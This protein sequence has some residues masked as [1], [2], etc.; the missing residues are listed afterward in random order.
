MQCVPER[1]T[2]QLALA[3]ARPDALIGSNFVREPSDATPRYTAWLNGLTPEQLATQFLREVTLARPTWF[4]ARG[5]YDRA[6]PFFPGPRQA[7][8]MRFFLSHVALGAPLA[9][10]PEPLV[11]YRH[12][13]SSSM[14]HA[15]AA[16]AC[17]HPA[18]AK[19]AQEAQAAPQESAPAVR[20]QPLGVDRELIW[21]LRVAALEDQL[22]ARHPAFAG[23]RFSIWNAGKEGRRLYRALRPESRARV[24]CLCDMSSRA[25]ELGKVQGGGGGQPRAGMGRPLLPF[26]SANCELRPSPP[27]FFL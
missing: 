26:F 1:I 9:K 22:L 27:P 5:V 2:R 19:E 4:C 21:A 6:G 3:Q 13:A 18:A 25:I 11:M 7:D 10:V 16:Q 14:G 15:L 24:A 20:P 17:T 8:D 23:K 12:H